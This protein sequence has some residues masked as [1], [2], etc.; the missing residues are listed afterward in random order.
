LRRA[1][2]APSD[3]KSDPKDL[4]RCLLCLTV[5]GWPWT[6]CALPS[7]SLPTLAPWRPKAPLPI[8]NGVKPAPPDPPTRPDGTRRRPDHVASPHPLWQPQLRNYRPMTPLNLKTLYGDRYV[9][10]RDREAMETPRDRS[11]W[12]YQIKTRVGVVYPYSDKLLAITC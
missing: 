2:C 10:S 4:L 6:P 3:P 1:A 11:P 8:R 12:L 9:I 7:N 5:P